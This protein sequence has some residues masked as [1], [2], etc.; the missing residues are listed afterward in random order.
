[1]ATAVVRKAHLKTGKKVLLGDG[2]RVMWSPVFDHNP[3]MT[4]KI[5]SDAVWVK[6][7][8]GHRPYID[9]TKSTPEKFVWKPF[10]AEPGE[11]YFSPE[12]LRWTETDFV[13]IEPN[14]KGSFGGNKDWGFDNWQKVVDALP[15]IRWIQGKGRPLRNVLQLETRSFRDACALLSR[16]FLFV[17]TDGGMH[18]AAAAL[19]LPA[20]VVW[21]GLIGPE[22]LGY[23]SHTNLCKASY[24]CGSILSCPHCRQALERITVGEVVW[25]VSSFLKKQSTTSQCI[26]PTSTPMSMRA[27]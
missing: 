15:D 24:F 8:G 2:S 14:T 26:G 3:R 20:V 6:N 10:K 5:G 12:E 22:T 9:Y 13:Y 23:E 19:G 11:L 7:Y 25:A 16:A 1:M 4:Q 18:H 17:G 27:T 21:G